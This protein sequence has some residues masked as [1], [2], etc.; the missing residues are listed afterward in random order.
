MR[1]AAR[2]GK[3]S[4]MKSRTISETARENGSAF[5]LCHER[6]RGL[7]FFERDFIGQ[8]APRRGGRMPMR[9]RRSAAAPSAPTPSRRAREGRGNVDRPANVEDVLLLERLVVEAAWWARRGLNDRCGRRP[10]RAGGARTGRGAAG[11][12]A[13]A[14]C[15]ASTADRM[16]DGMEVFHERL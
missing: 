4:S 1:C 9:Q 7:E 8:L 13:R 6:A 10:A 5:S 15:S 2:T 12:R 14:D 3:H 16:C 11:A